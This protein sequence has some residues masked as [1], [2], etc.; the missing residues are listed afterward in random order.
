LSGLPTIGRRT[1]AKAAEPF[2][3]SLKSSEPAPR[4]RRPSLLDGLI[5]VAATAVCLALARIALRE[6]ELQWMLM[7]RVSRSAVV[8]RLVSFVALTWTLCYFPIRFRKPR[9]PFSEIVRQPGMVACTAACMSIVFGASLTVPGVSLAL[10]RRGPQPLAQII[11]ASV[12]NLVI[13]HAVAGAWLTLRLSG[14]WRAEPGWIDGMGRALGI[15]WIL[16][17]AFLNYQILWQ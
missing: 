7:D 13:A 2:L 5:V 8:F 14:A 12:N 6:N 3:V 9:P 11:E 10:S 4:C 16:S 1:H 15:Y 17:L